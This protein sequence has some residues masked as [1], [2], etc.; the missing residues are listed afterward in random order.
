MPREEIEACKA[1]LDKVSILDEAKIAR[2]FAGVSAM[3]M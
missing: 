2:D 1:F 3:T